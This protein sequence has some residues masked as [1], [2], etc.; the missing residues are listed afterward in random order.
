M[1]SV[2]DRAAE[3]STCRGDIRTTRLSSNGGQSAGDQALAET[4]YRIWT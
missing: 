1:G 2:L 3:P 4:V